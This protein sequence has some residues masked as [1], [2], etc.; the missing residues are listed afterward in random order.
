MSASAVS[1][2][3][4]CLL[5][6]SAACYISNCPIGGKRSLPDPVRQCMACGPGNRGR[7]FGPSIC[8]GEGLGCVLGSP[9][10]ARC[11]E[12]NYL[13]SPCEAGGRPCGAD[14]GRCAAPGICCDAE[15]CTIDQSC[16]AEDDD[17]AQTGHSENSS[18]GLGRDI[19]VRLLH[20]AGHTPPHR[21]HQ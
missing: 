13:P 17:D 3:V 11:V 21:V 18:T 1:V 14:S 9:E 7:C 4:L 12:E 10:A 19:L 15:G 8:C 6:L 2:Y 20:L 16:L 5:S